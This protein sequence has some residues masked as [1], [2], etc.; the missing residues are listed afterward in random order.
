MKRKVMMAFAVMMAVALAACGGSKKDESRTAQ[1]AETEAAADENEDKGEEDSNEE[2]PRETVKLSMFV[3]EPWWP[4]SDWSGT[5]PR[6]A[7]EQTGVDFDVTVAADTT[8]LD[9]MVASGT[10]PDVIISSDFNLLSDESVCYDW[11]SLIDEYGM[12]PVHPA[13]QFVNTANDGKFYTIMV[14]WSADYEYEQY[15]SVNPEGVCATAR[16]D[17]YNAACEALGITEI[18]TLE[19]L[20]AAMEICKEKYPDV[21]PYIFGSEWGQDR[22]MSALYGC[23][24]EGF[25]DRDGKAILWISQDR[26]KDLMMK[27]NEW[28]RKGYILEENF[29][30]S[31]VNTQYEWCYSGNCFIAAALSNAASNMDT[32]SADAGADFKWV[33][34]TDIHTDNN[35]ICATA[36]GWRGSFISRN[37]KDPEA[38]MRMAEFLINK[39]TGYTMLWGV[40]GEDWSW[41]EDKTIATFNYS[42]ADPNYTEL[43]AERQFKWGWLGHDGISNNM[44]YT[45]APKTRQSLEWVGSITTRNPALGLVMNAMQSDSEEYVIYQNLKELDKNYMVKIICAGSEEEAAAQYDEMMENAKKLGVEKVEDWANSIYGEKIAAYNEVKGIGPEGWEK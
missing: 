16:E 24:W 19:D 23:A 15:P 27:M 22:Y 41:N 18:A 10:L 4:Y 34:L 30:W 1:S 11:G 45:A 6:W 42:Q 28:Y 21:T 3:D 26:R 29:S 36:T 40:E 33:P 20:E 5:M 14:G 12:D 38:A 9:L 32:G 17:I 8:E 13:Y 39:E 35:E 44:A 7:T 43:N 2:T 37:C 25:A 31:N